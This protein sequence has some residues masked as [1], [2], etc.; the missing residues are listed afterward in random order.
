MNGKIRFCGILAAATVLLAGCAV[1]NNFLQP[2]DFAERLRRDGV[3]VESVREVPP[4]PFRATSGCAIKVAGSEIGVYK[5]D[6]SVAVQEKRIEGIA[7]EKKLF[8]NGLPYPVVVSGSFVFMGLEKNPEKH[9]ILESI[10]NF[11]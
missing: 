7:A 10:R 11:K 9:R 3:A 5:F 2:G 4:H 8:I 1:H 6:R